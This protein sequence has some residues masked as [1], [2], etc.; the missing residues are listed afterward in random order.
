MIKSKNILI[1]S[2]N[3][4]GDS[5]LSSGLHDFFSRYHNTKITLVCGK[6]PSELFKYCQNVD[7]TIILRKRKY[8]LH[9]FDLW[10]KLIFTQWE[11]IID[12]R[13]T[14]ISF[15]LLSKKKYIYRKK[16]NNK[17]EHK[18]SEITRA[19]TG[20][21]I[22]P[23]IKLLSTPTLKNN[24]LKKIIQL[25]KHH[26]LVMVAPTA[27]WMGKIWPSDRYLDLVKNLIKEQGFK[28]SIFIF[29]GPRSEK[30]LVKKIF[31]AKLPYILDLFG[32]SSLIEIF[33]IMKHCSF[34]IGNDSGL[35]HMAALAKIRTFGLFGPSDKFKYK[36]WGNGNICISS[37]K[38]PEQLMGYK[39]FDARNCGSLML[40]LKTQKVLKHIID[41]L[42]KK[43]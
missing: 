19:V 36:P 32:K 22:H 30:Y 26:K 28:K 27:N 21:I 12:L 24:N 9:W 25:R 16:K 8:S 20:Q 41:N 14:G 35:M 6:L 23:S 10:S 38:T 33:N 18:V 3:R 4:L 43:K 13:G 2:S 37:S 17:N 39:G 11:F 42:K 29:V 7:N 1:I 31:R 5:I 40:H 34:F 15:F